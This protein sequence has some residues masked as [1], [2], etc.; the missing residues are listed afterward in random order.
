MDVREMG[1]QPPVIILDHFTFTFTLTSVSWV[2]YRH[3][4]YYFRYL[5]SW[6]HSGREHSFFFAFVLLLLLLLEL[7]QP[8]KSCACESTLLL[9]IYS[10]QPRQSWRKK[11]LLPTKADENSLKFGCDVCEF[12]PR[13]LE[14]WCSKFV[15]EETGRG[16]HF[17]VRLQLH[18]PQVSMKAKPDKEVEPRQRLKCLL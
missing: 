10:S 17:L 9:L 12:S 11:Q 3:T 2:T 13:S 6:K 15:L 8:H 1:S 4:I 18:A 5:H 16:A 14:L 7:S